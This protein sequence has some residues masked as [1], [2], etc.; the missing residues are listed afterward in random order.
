MGGSAGDNSTEGAGV[1]VLGRVEGDLAAVSTGGRLD[2]GSI[3]V[4]LCRMVKGR[5]GRDEIVRTEGGEVIGGEGDFS[6][7]TCAGEGGE[8]HQ[9]TLGDG[10]LDRLE[11]GASGL[12]EMGTTSEIRLRWGRTGLTPSSSLAFDLASARGRGTRR[13]LL[14]SWRAAHLRYRCRGCSPG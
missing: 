13:Q 6:S 1:V 14:S 12:E 7:A 5:G 2:L 11:L 3:L 9:Q 8:G 10:R 4:E